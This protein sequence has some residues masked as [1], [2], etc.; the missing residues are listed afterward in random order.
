MNEE[1]KYKYCDGVKVNSGFYVGCLGFV[2]D[3]DPSDLVVKYRINGYKVLGDDVK[4]FKVW[5]TEGVL[6]PY[7][8]VGDKK[9]RQDHLLCQFINSFIKNDVY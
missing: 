7:D 3:V 9:K 1:T 5:L 4:K 8:V 2:L 6:D